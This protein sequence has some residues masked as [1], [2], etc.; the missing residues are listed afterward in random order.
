MF[1]WLF[2]KNCVKSVTHFT[3]NRDCRVASLL[4]M[5]EREMDSRLRGNDI[6]GSGND[7]KG[8]GNDIRRDGSDESDPYVP[9]HLYPV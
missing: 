8:S 4:A 7:I 9:T 5:T 6:K 2:K 3:F 1:S